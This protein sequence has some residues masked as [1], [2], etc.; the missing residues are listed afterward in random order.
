MRSR[1]RS[2]NSTKE[3][4]IRCGPTSK[5]SSTPSLKSSTVNRVPTPRFPPEARGKRKAI[6]SSR[7]HP[8]EEEMSSATLASRENSSTVASPDPAVNPLISRPH[9][10]TPNPQTPPPGGDWRSLFGVP[11]FRD[12]SQ[13]CNR[14]PMQFSTEEQLLRRDVKRFRGGLVFKAHRLVYQA[15]LPGCVT[16]TGVP[17]SSKKRPP[18]R[19]L[20]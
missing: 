8:R 9:P 19:T 18:H 7:I 15:R 20:Q 6:P 14:L 17:R 2:A 11:D 1:W 5:S 4:R 13:V 16:G 10:Q 12:A 3:A